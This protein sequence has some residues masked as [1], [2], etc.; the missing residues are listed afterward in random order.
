MKVCLVNPPSPFLLDEAVFPPLGLLYLAAAI[1]EHDPIFVDVGV[2]DKIPEGYNVYAITC[3]I[4]QA[5]WVKKNRHL[6]KGAAIVGGPYASTTPEDFSDYDRVVI[7][8]G[9]NVIKSIVE[10]DRILPHRIQIPPPPINEI[11]FPARDLIDIHKYKYLLEG[12]PTTTMVTS[13]GCPY[14][15][16]FCS[17]GVWER[18]RLRSAENVIEELQDIKALGFSGLMIYDDVFTLNRTRVM[19]ICEEL[20]RL[21]FKWAC[22]GRADMDINLLRIMKNSGCVRISFGIESGS[23]TI[24]DNVGKRTT[25]AQ[26]TRVVRLC[27]ELGIDTRAFLIVGL[28]GESWET[29]EETKQWLRDAKPTNFGLGIFMPYPG[30]DIYNHPEKYDI[31]IHSADL[32]DLWYRGIPGKYNCFVETSK[33]S[34]ED[35]VKAREEISEEFDELQRYK[36]SKYTVDSE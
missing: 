12:R 19:T 29:I 27:N 20:K 22:F 4:T 30:C 31:K 17:K 8:E 3:N 1:R 15:C 33:M 35:I 25:V 7:G 34:R 26:N 23:Q 5:T 28:P 6:F 11:K 36:E 14:N 16:A 2:G 9:E 18:T 21:D 10:C 32:A 13:R 24:L